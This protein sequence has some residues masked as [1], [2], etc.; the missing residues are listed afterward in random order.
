MFSRSPTPQSRSGLSAADSD[1]NCDRSGVNPTPAIVPCSATLQSASKK[2]RRALLI[3]QVARCKGR[4]FPAQQKS[5]SALSILAERPLTSIVRAS[6]PSGTP[7]IQT[8]SIARARKVGLS[9]HE[10]VARHVV[11]CLKRNSRVRRIPALILLGLFG[12]SAVTPK[13]RLEMCG[14][15]C[16][17]G[18]SV[19]RPTGVSRQQ[20]SRSRAR[21]SFAES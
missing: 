11:N 3:A 18:C 20:T 15:G 1:N 19:N 6:H 2:K 16:P 8:P 13:P 10:F 14:F 9:L 7:A 21:A 12:I 17:G 5:M 4:T